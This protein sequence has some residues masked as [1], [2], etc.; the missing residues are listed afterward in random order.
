M[1]KNKSIIVLLVL[2]FNSLYSLDFRAGE[3]AK[4]KIIINDIEFEKTTEVYV[5]DSSKTG[6]NITVVKGSKPSFVDT[7]FWSNQGVFIPGRIVKLNPYVMSKYEVTQE[8]YSSVMKD[9]VVTVENFEFKLNSEPYRCKNFDDYPTQPNDIQKYRPA[10]S[11]TWYDA[12]FFC[13][14]LTEKTMSPE[15]KAYNIIVKSISPE[16]NIVDAIVTLDISKKG[17]RL[18]TEAEWE[19]AARGGNQQLDDWN[20]C[21]SG[22][23]KGNI[24]FEQFIALDGTYNEMGNVDSKLNSLCWYRFVYLTSET[25]SPRG[26]LENETHEVGLKI[27]NILGLYDMNGNVSEWCYDGLEK[28][29]PT[30]EFVNPVGKLKSDLRVIRGGNSYDTLDYISVTWRGWGNEP[31][32]SY[33]NVGFRI[34]RSVIE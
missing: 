31:Y 16:G 15:D 26:Y 34:V 32:K 22:A 23:P 4:E 27:P 6:K 17:Y 30:G 13:N 8:L 33:R 29:L 12:V 25:G 3:I 28:N 9:Q 19:F 10:D 14:A 24:T 21:Y 5:I 20:Y 11:I 7:Q 2:C 1:K 18:P